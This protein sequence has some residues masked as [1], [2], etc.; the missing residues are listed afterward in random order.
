MLFVY[1]QNCPNSNFSNLNFNNWIGTT[2]TTPALGFTPYSY[3]G[4][5]ADQHTII[6]TPGLDPQT[7]NNLSMLPPGGSTSCRLGNPENGY[8][9]ESMTYQMQIDNTN[10][11]FIYEYAMVL[12]DPG[13]SHSIAEKPK[14]IVKVMDL[15]NNV[16]SG[17]CSYYETYGGDPNN[18]FA[19]VNNGV[20]YSDW[21]KVAIDL[22]NY[23]IPAIKIQFT[24]LDCDQGG[25]WGYAYLSTYCQNLSIDMVKNCDGTVVLTAPPG[26]HSYLWSPG[27]QLTQSITLNNLST[28]NYSYSCSMNA[29]AGL[30]CPSQIDTTF[31]YIATPTINVNDET[32]CIGESIT[33]NST[34]NEVGGTYSWSPDGQIT[35]SII[36]SPTTTTNYILSYSALNN[37][38]YTDTA[39]IIVNP[40]PAFTVQ[41][42]SVCMNDTITLS[43]TPTNL[44]YTWSNGVINNVPFV[45]LISNTYTVNALDPL[46]GCIDEQSIFVTVNPNP[47][48]NF[49][50]ICASL[51]ALF[52]NA[53]IGGNNYIWNMGDGEE[54]HYDIDIDYS[55][56]DLENEYY[57]VT[58]TAISE[59]GCRDSI[60]KNFITPFLHYVPNTFTPDY[61]E[62]NN[63]FIPIFSQKDRIDNYTLTI[64]NRWGEV[65]FESYDIKQG[66]DGMYIN[67]KAQ[68]GTYNWE[69]LYNESRCYNKRLHF[70]GNVNLIR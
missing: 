37:C 61:N 46:T 54:L 34:C 28:G 59:F 35:P 33:L 32:I 26:F 53:S 69:I 24:T 45:P 25:H 6:S 38:I 17:N 21:K 42:V 4:F 29:I 12:Q 48:A 3:P 15:S 16:L 23:S 44:T 19:Y 60:T 11:L 63:V 43:P 31:D 67:E 56:F 2:G 49:T 39:T 18:N 27:G 57:P 7:L 20:T 36:V 70:H 13:S 40:L 9:A 47:I 58:L 8:G 68:D 30:S 66:W 22:S 5:V 14:F 50:F 51:P 62:F 1:L 10:N 64:Y 52:T 65:V 55:F 41:D